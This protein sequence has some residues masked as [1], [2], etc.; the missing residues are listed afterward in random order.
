MTRPDTRARAAPE[1]LYPLC[2]P[3]GLTSHDVVAYVRRVTGQRHSGHAGTLDPGAAG[4]LLALVGRGATRLAEYLVELPKTYVA[5]VIFGVSTDTQDY[6]GRPTGGDPTAAGRLDRDAVG[7]ALAAF[8]NGYHQVPP[9]VSAVKVGGERLYRS[10]LD[11]RPV[12]RSPRWVMIHRLTLLEYSGPPGWR[13]PPV[14]RY[15]ASRPAHLPWARIR[16]TC[17]KG[18]YVRTLAHDLGSALGTGAHLGFLLRESVGGF[19]LARSSTLEELAEA[20]ESG[21]LAQLRVS[22]AEATAHLPAVCPSGP[23]LDRLRSGSAIDCPVGLDGSEPAVRVLGPD[24]G[25]AL[26]ARVR[27]GRLEPRKVLGPGGEDPAGEVR[28]GRGDQGD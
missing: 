26:I 1:G 22:P 24:G 14:E 17:S 2:K 12:E 21:G 18:T 28:S 6:S 3:P 10:A 16:V 7:G 5:E 23:E 9:M 4:V 25:L 19:D 8:G 20:A 27:G 15:V 11:G 13:D